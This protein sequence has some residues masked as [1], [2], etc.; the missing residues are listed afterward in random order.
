MYK[1]IKFQGYDRIGFSSL[2]FRLW[3]KK[4][5]FRLFKLNL[6][7]FSSLISH[8]FEDHRIIEHVY[9]LFE[10][11]LFYLLFW[12]QLKLLKN[13]KW[14]D[15]RLYERKKELKIHLNRTNST[16]KIPCMSPRDETKLAKN[17]TRDLWKSKGQLYLIEFYCRSIFIL[18]R[19]CHLI[20]SS[21]FFHKTQNSITVKTSL[22]VEILRNSMQNRF[23]ILD[24]IF[25]FPIV[26]SIQ[27]EIHQTKIHRKSLITAPPLSLCSNNSSRKKKSLSLACNFSISHT[28]CY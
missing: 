6:T 4:K 9:F 7:S 5:I 19:F 25:A 22:Y 27:N 10:F 16:A 2:L 8:F 20:F 28:L 24:N 3:E 11:W 23:S 14:S 1:I 12:K 21:R 13:E 15:Y 26:T 18:T 17:Y